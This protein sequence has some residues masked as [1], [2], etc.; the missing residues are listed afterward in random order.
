MKPYYEN[1]FGQL[2]HGDC[3]E[4]MDK[5]ENKVDMVLCDLPYGVTSAEWDKQIPIDKL[6][7][8]YANMISDMGAICLFGTEPFSSMLRTS[9]IKMYKYD[10]IWE[11]K[12]PSGFLHAKNRPLNIHENISVFS[13]GAVSHVGQSFNRMLYNAQKTG[14]KV[15]RKKNIA[16]NSGVLLKVG[17]AKSEAYINQV[18]EYKGFYPKT[19]LKYQIHNVGLL[20]P[21]QK[22]TDLCEFLIKSYTNPGMVVLDNA[23]GSGT[24][25]EACINTGRKFILIE[26]DESFC[27]AAAKRLSAHRN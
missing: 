22:P 5:L 23:C 27:E 21:T 20:H 2:Y 15:Y 14:D 8:H 3:L 17:G 10:W 18:R 24:T 12:R 11:K 1:Q 4:I 25:G 6:W 16:N 19:I 7:R 13:K 26:K 9:N